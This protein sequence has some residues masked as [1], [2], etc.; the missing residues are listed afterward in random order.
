MSKKK[1]G[2]AILW[3]QH[4]PYYKSSSGY[5]QMPW[6]RFH[7]TKDYLDMLL[8]QQEFPSIK[9]NFNFVPSLLLQIQDY[10]KNEAEDNIWYLTKKPADELSLE[11]KK[12][13]LSDFFL[14]NVDG[15]IR[16][17]QRFYELYLK[18][19]VYLK[20]KPLERKIE[21]FSVEDFR[22]LQVW[23]NLAWIGLESRKREK[24]AELFQKGKH[25]SEQDKQLLIKESRKI[26]ED[27]IPTLKKMW[28]SGQIELSTTP[29]YHP[30]LPLLCD[31]YVARQSSP[32]ITLPQRHFV[33]SEDAEIQVEKGLEYFEKLFGERPGGM[34]PSEGSV[35]VAAL[36]IIA[37]QG[38]DWV[39]TDGGILSNTLK[40]EFSHLKLYQPFLLD[41]GRHQ[42]NLFFRDHYLSDAIGFVY[43]N[44]PAERAVKDFITRVYS[45]RKLLVQKYSEDEL[46][47]FVVP[48]ILDGENCWE[49]YKDDGKP[50]LRELY[51]SISEDP[52]LETVTLGEVLK[53]NGD[54]ERLT[55]LHPGSWIN[56]NF[57][58]WIGADED[59]KAWDILKDTRDFLVKEEKLGIHS[60]ETIT[61][62][63]EQIY[64]AEGSDWNW[65][66]G[67]E[68]S[69]AN[70]AEFDQL[71]RE[72][73]MEVYRLLGYDVPTSL[74]QTIKRVHFDRFVSTRP[75]NFIHP[76]IDGKSSFFYEWVGA[77]IYEVSKTPQSAMHQ[78]TGILDRFYVG[79]DK[80][81][82][83]LRL[84]FLSSPD[85]LTEF[86]LAVKRPHRLTFVV[87]PLRGVLEKF[88]VNGEGQKKIN[89]E[90][91]FK[92]DKVLEIGI[93]FKELEVK[94]ED[95][96]GFQLQLKLNGQPLEE[97]PRSSL[98]DVEVPS[99]Y[100]DLIEW[101][102]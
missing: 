1:L 53:R 43:S 32:G 69:S 73:L 17:Y 35:S 101:S 45:I 6:V 5:Y 39:A 59:N 25:Y 88:K 19:K 79:F 42:I 81:Y 47:K 7:S 87:S 14:A 76:W 78:V 92:M 38:I 74:Y 31:N 66:Y 4:Q 55:T 36:E 77:A 75:K 3:H 58:I 40:S 65:W 61:Q 49:Y 94:P 8:V 63:W 50:F 93:L 34:W 67:D 56:S 99:E 91:F 89:L 13:I 57:N 20:N 68:H 16:P 18:Y 23:Y 48:I 97:F 2:I 30:I 12:K 98:I 60:S 84:D 41:T 102:V 22:D 86:V 54:P 100:F 51:T 70:D 37:S 52:L 64:I 72:H 96:L 85:P 27:I 46:E 10:V 33:H 26:M 21:S 62:A 28:Q 83:Y 11:D 80:N 24:I 71:Y 15:M 95:I 29:F 90:P 9:Q 82:L 44:W